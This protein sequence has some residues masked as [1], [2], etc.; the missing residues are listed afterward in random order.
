[1]KR[2]LLLAV[3]ALAAGILALAGSCSHPLESDDIGGGQEPSPNVV[4]V[5]TL[6]I[7]DTVMIIDTGTVYDTVYNFDT[8]VIIDSNFTFD[9]VYYIDTVFQVDTVVISNPGTGGP[10]FVCAT[11]STGEKEIVW[12]FRNSPGRFLLEFAASSERIDPSQAVTVKIGGQEYEWKPARDSE[13]TIEQDLEENTTI[14][15]T[16]IKPPSY[17]HSISICLK[18]TQM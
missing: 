13:L 1:M 7:F 2:I 11:L 17:G 14:R 4:R 18:M 10:L 6:L 16:P 12:L 8:L 15:I 5:D 9:T 3:L